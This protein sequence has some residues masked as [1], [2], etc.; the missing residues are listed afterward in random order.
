MTNRSSFALACAS[1][2]LLGLSFPP[3]QF[4]LLACVG[5]VPLFVL[6]DRVE[7]Y[8]RALRYSYVVFLLFNLITLYWVGGFAHGKDAFLM[9]AGGALLIAHPV[10]FLVPIV[11]YFFVN[12]NLG[13]SI[14]L[15]SIPFIWV[16]FEWLHSLGEV[17]FPWLTLGNTQTYALER[18]QF[19]TFTGVYGISFWIVALNAI[20][21]FLYRKISRR[22]WKLIS[23]R[24]VVALIILI[25]VTLIPGIHGRVALSTASPMNRPRVRVGII[26]PNLDPWK[27][28]QASAEGQIQNYLQQSQEL[29][30]QK[31]EL[32]IWPET[33]IAFR[34]LSGRYSDV[35]YQLRTG[36]DSLGSAL[37]T[38]FADMV[39]YD[40]L[41]A[42]A[43]SKIVRGTN[44]H[45]DDFN[46]MMLLE[47]RSEKVQKYAKIKLVPFGERVPYA[48]KLS[49]LAIAIKWDVGISGW[50]TGRD[51]TVF[52]LDRQGSQI[53]FSGMICYESIYPDLVSA[54]VRKGAQFLVIITNDSWW[55]NTSGAY[56]H[57][58][59]AVLRAIENRRAIARCANGGVSCLIDRFGRIS[60]E[61]D[62]Y[63][64]ASIAGDVQLS[65]EK[66]FYSMYG[67]VFSQTCTAIG[68]LA[69]SGAIVGRFKKNKSSGDKT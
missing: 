46:A 64:R 6:L 1:G 26:Q 57:K 59:C 31:P 5:L 56:Q 21:Y 39:F 8:P 55:G 44:A 66:T 17:G 54:F 52:V 61:R 22:E 48:E 36:I 51:T 50:G 38:G 63:T 18:I 65:T 43:A 58:Q 3:L 42:P 9:L 4:G 45:Y 11:A 37:L 35:F 40:S 2:I 62:L 47:P 32:T 34:I 29:V 25:V 14:A 67:D 12:K 7:S 49:F 13:V 28:W 15:I 30:G 16:G 33:A 10:F 23:S 69:L 24:S 19:I 53:P 27:K 60:E 20:V 68:F 41:S